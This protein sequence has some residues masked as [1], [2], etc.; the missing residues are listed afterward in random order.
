MLQDTFV[1]VF[2]YA[3]SFR[4][5]HSASFRVWVRT[6][7]SNVLRRARASAPRRWV[8]GDDEIAPEIPDTAFGPHLRVV[9][10]EDIVS[11]RGAWSLFLQHYARAFA[12]LSPR[13]RTALDMVEVQGLGYAETGRRLG[14][15]P[16]NMKMIM[17]RARRR[18]QM[19]MRVAMD[20]ANEVPESGAGSQRERRSA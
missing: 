10:G 11:L 12:A 13:D 9:H 6:I 3:S 8:G 7:A 1:N 17:L 14:V 18:L 19:H 16:S 5:D 15:G 4:T 2:R 20:A